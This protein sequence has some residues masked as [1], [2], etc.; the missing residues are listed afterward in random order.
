[1]GPGDPGDERENMISVIKE[2]LEGGEYSIDPKAVAAAMLIR[3]RERTKLGD[4][5]SEVLVAPQVRGCDP[6]E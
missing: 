1:M 5:W 3:G 4:L 2:R 6:D